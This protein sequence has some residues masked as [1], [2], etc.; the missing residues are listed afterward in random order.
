M[1]DAIARV[2]LDYARNYVKVPRE[3]IEQLAGDP[4]TLAVFA[5][6][7]SRARW[8]GGAVL[9]GGHGVIE[10]EPGQAV[11]G[12]DE[13]AK[14]CNTTVSRIRTALL[15]LKKLGYVAIKTANR[16]T[17]VTVL[18]YG[19][20]A[21]ATGAKS[22]ADAP[23]DRQIVARSSPDD[24]QMIATNKKE[25]GK[26]ERSTEGKRVRTRATVSPIDASWIPRSN[27]RDLAK[28]LGVDPDHEAAAF[29]DHHAAK[30]STFANWNAAFSGWLRRA[31]TFAPKTGRINGTHV[32]RAAPAS[33]DDF[34]RDVESAH[35]WD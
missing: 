14:L 2:L 23:D 9:R 4:L 33:A 29:R 22:P 10:L 5:L 35:E 20:I 19:G 34:T 15:H 8:T 11:I 18:G 31:P 27:E 7:I 25:E 32:G 26:K 6:I 24:R 21:E 3:A 30:G 16:G 1:S 17:I 13:L 28:T 12:R